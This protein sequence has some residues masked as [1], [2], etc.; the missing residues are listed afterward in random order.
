MRPARPV[1]QS[2]SQRLRRI[3]LLTMGTAMLA[4]VVLIGL[5]NFL[6]ALYAKIEVTRVQAGILAEN[7]AAALMFEDDKAAEEL[8]RSLGSSPD[9]RMAAIHR[10]DGGTFA[11]YAT[12]TQAPDRPG[13][14]LDQPGYRMI[15]GF[16]EVVQPIGFEGQRLGSLRL[17]VDLASLYRQTLLQGGFALIALLLA[18]TLAMFLLTRLNRSVVAPLQGLTALTARV[19]SSGNYATRAETGEISELND[20][21]AGF[22]AMLEQIQER[23]SRLASHR[24]ELEREVDARTL[25]LR[26]AKEAAEA[27]SQAKSEFLATMSH[28][29]RTPMNGV[30][31]MAELLLVTPLDATQRHYAE[32][33]EQSGRHLL[34][35]IN[36]ILDFSKIESGKLELESVDFDPRRLADDTLALFAQ[37]AIAKGLEIACDLPDELPAAVSGDPTRLRQILANLLSNAIKFTERG[38]IVLRA[39][40]LAE[41]ADQVRLRLCV[42]DTGIGIAPRA[43]GRIFEHFAQADGST[44]RKYGGTGLGLAICKRL[45]EMMGGA[46]GVTSAPGEGSSFCV[47][48][49]LGKAAGAPLPT[50][51]ASVLRDVSVLVVDDHQTNRTIL[52]RQLSHLGMRARSAGDGGMA[53]VAMRAA[54]DSGQPYALVLLDMHMPGMDGLALAREIRADPRLAD[55]RLIL[56]SSTY[57]TGDR[58]MRES[59][60]IVRCL[61]KPIRHA[62]LRQALVEALRREDRSAPPPAPVPAAP[63]LAGR[64]LL[65]ED[66]PVNQRV[67]CAM[68]A[69]L[70]VETHVAGNGIEA[71]AQAAEQD[72]DLILMDCQMPELDGY[73]ASRRIRRRE[74]QA[75]GPARRIPI[76]ALT[77]NAMEGDREKCLAAGMDDYLTKPFTLEQLRGV[78]R[79]WLPQDRLGPGDVAP[80]TLPRPAD[81]PDVAASQDL[82]AINPDKLASIR[83]LDPGGGN[84]LLAQIVSAF[85]DNIPSVMIEMRSG[86]PAGDADRLRRA[87]HGLKSSAGNVGAETL[88]GLCRQVE[89]KARQGDLAAM[90]A[91]VN[92][93]E[94]E[95]ARASDALAGFLE[96][97]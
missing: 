54:V 36:D 29:I 8:L 67:A 73:D 65:A 58:A 47:D 90:D 50:Q 62:E 23:D 82:G 93:I 85:R 61:N 20:L 59:A 91:L 94:A 43:Q 56:L 39:Q 31:G 32:A 87:A 44:T 10:A 30:L 51:D 22:N 81:H 78:L 7:A 1:V 13:L 49:P 25:E 92:E 21:A 97:G 70:G 88:A 74:A 28:E 40:V 5:G 64:V 27:A 66:N 4:L 84:R 18:M 71:A 41:D 6:T 34:G 76:L 52:E 12:D 86:L 89:D 33:V 77:A 37:Q 45:V 2:I 9:Y 19:S 42:Q 83:A 96:G 35:I 75:P 53:L 79:R 16:L 80:Q 69:L 24:D 46:I 55:S 63:A 48:L 95:A 38:E 14:P 68:L 11:R 17:G 72:F 26:A 60:G 3:N 57:Q 15:G